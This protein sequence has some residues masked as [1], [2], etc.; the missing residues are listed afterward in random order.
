MCWWKAIKMRKSIT[1]PAP[2]Y[3]NFYNFTRNFQLAPFL[4]LSTILLDKYL[5]FFRAIYDTNWNENEKKDEKGKFS[6]LFLDVIEFNSWGWMGYLTWIKIA[7]LSTNRN[8]KW[9]NFPITQFL[10]IILLL[11]ARAFQIH[12]VE[13]DEKTEKLV[14]SSTFRRIM[15]SL[16]R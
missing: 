2:L 1:L 11:V 7:F 9:Q 8:L 3:T 12:S 14:D 4:W 5:L 15:N 16:D 6:I 10:N 13:E